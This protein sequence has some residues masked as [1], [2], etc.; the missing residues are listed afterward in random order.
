MWV[1]L[2]AGADHKSLSHSGN[3]ITLWPTSGCWCWSRCGLIVPTAAAAAAGCSSTARLETQKQS[4]VVQEQN[5]SDFAKLSQ[6]VLSEK[7]RKQK[8][9]SLWIL[10]FW[11]VSAEVY[12]WSCNFTL[13][14][15][16]SPGLSRKPSPLPPTFI[17]LAAPCLKRFFLNQGT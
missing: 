4:H 8:S 6:H 11:P 5:S 3:S 2:D 7:Q 12:E 1:Y 10:W 9:T 17:L 14:D 16:P 13:T 15:D